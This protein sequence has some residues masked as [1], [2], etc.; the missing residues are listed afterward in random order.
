[1]FRRKFRPIVPSPIIP[2]CAFSISWII[3]PK[4]RLL[5]PSRRRDPAY[6][7]N[8]TTHRSPFARKP[9]DEA[10]T[11]LHETRQQIEQR[12][13]QVGCLC[14]ISIPATNDNY[15]GIQLSRNRYGPRN[16][17]DRSRDKSNFLL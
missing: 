1:M 10:R 15:S 12:R 17:S 9:T 7:R 6:P 14:L 13:I 2:K 8:S 5:L 11:A 3:R 4:Y 16:L